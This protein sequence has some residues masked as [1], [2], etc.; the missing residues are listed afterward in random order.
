MPR[1]RVTVKK[2]TRVGFSTKGKFWF[3]KCAAADAVYVVEHYCRHI[4][5]DLAGEL[6]RLQPHQRF[7]LE[8]LF[9]WKRK[10]AALPA[11][12]SRRYRTLYLEEPRKN[13]KSTEAA[14]IAVCVLFCDKE[15]GAQLYSAATEKDQARIVFNMAKAMIEADEELD[16]RA[17]CLK[18]AIFLHEWGS[19]YKPLSS[20]A[21]SK[22][23]Y[24]CHAFV[25]D[26]VH[27]HGDRDL[28]D[29]LRTSMGSRRQPLEI[30]ITTAGV[31]RESIGWELHQRAAGIIKGDLVDDSFLPFIYG[32]T[33]KDDWKSPKIWKKANPNLGVSVR[34]DYLAQEC[35]RAEQ[36]P[37]YQNTFKRLHL[38]IWTS[39]Q[40]L[41]LDMD[42]WEACKGKIDL[43]TLQ[44]Q[45]CYAA[46]DL[47]STTDLSA[48]GLLFPRPTGKKETRDIVPRFDTRTERVQ[49][50]DAVRDGKLQPEQIEVE[51]HEFVLIPR[52]YVPED[53]IERRT[54]EDK[55]PYDAWVRDGHLIATPGAIIDYDFIRADINEAGE[56][57]DIQ[58]IA[59]DRWNATQI[60][61]QLAGDG[62]EV[63]FHGQGFASMGQPTRD[64]GAM[65]LD[66]RVVHDGHPVMDWC[67]SNVA[68]DIDPAGFPKP[69]KGKSTERID[70]AVVAIMALGRAM[71]VEAD[72]GT[73]IPEDYEVVAI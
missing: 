24:N 15:P 3:D 62:F 43:E 2:Q 70:G 71:V 16:S 49:W 52:F 55:V 46:L 8:E 69:N 36:T 56:E 26:E 67:I 10:D 37:A 25:C 33:L 30:Y 6:I 38:N 27:V 19:V 57:Y 39:Q 14:Y 12:C 65:V 72:Q 42:R 63:L 1:Q 5:G 9:G 54:G 48:F 34:E 21:K 32:A 64:F 17:E 68:V 51:K 18:D 44:G 47:S 73:E 45:P 11:D 29:V 40:D 50:H 23:G 13:G 7:R 61:T 22:H 41:W 35:L 59:I 66:K 4:E 28:I 58:E 60:T 53:A 31:S 20:D